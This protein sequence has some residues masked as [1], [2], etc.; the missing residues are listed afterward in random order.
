MDTSSKHLI[1]IP[2]VILAGGK[3]TRVT[4]IS[5]GKPKCLLPVQGRPFLFWIFDDL[6]AAGFS[7]VVLALSYKAEEIIEAVDS[8]P[9]IG[10]LDLS[11]TLDS[12]QGSGTGGC[13]INLIQM[14]PHKFLVQYGDSKMR[15]DYGDF[16]N[17]F[18]NID[19]MSLISVIESRDEEYL[20]NIRIQ[21]GKIKQYRKGGGLDF[22]Y[23]DYGLLGIN[24]IH[25]VNFLNTQKTNDFDLSEFQ[26][27]AV[28]ENL[29][30]YYEAKREFVEIGT[31]ISYGRA[32][33][34]VHFLR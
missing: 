24:K 5:Q 33:S 32:M 9:A 3:G 19:N 11:W 20:A 34:G 18:V 25:F 12:P 16:C 29:F 26:E 4:S 10:K 15:L 30:C 28:R 17:T 1:D 21:N 31:P 14:L 8:Y 22:N 2:I 6:I 7:K 23:I 27:A 13:L